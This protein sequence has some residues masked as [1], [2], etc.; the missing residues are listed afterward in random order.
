M[1]K[2]NYQAYLA[3]DWEKAGAGFAELVQQRPDD[4]PTKNLDKVIN[5][6]GN[7]KAPA[8]W[9]GYRPLTSK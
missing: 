9:K 4:G 8:D 1:F 3:G 5:I 2:E 7:R 6:K